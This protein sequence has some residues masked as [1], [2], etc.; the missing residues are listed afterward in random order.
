MA[1]QT[2]TLKA[3][4]IERYGKP[5]RITAD[6][7]YDKP[8]FY[9]IFSKYGIAL[10]IVAT[11]AHNQNGTIGAGNRVLHMFSGVQGYQNHS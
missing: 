10:S 4:W 3:L 1:M 11:E 7:E 2:E 9:E 6:S 8:L 5:K